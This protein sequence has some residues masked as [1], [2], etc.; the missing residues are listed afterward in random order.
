[1]N[2]FYF[3]PCCGLISVF[4]FLRGI[5][6]EWIGGV[7]VGTGSRFYLPKRNM[8]HHKQLV[9][10]F[11][12]E[13][14]I[15]LRGIWTNLRSISGTKSHGVFIFLRGIWTGILGQLIWTW[16]IVFIFLRGIWTSKDWRSGNRSHQVFIFLRGIWTSHTSFLIIDSFWFLSS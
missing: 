7:H 13:V 9:L 14:F 6:T 16:C 15:F 8:N 12:G 4:I 3:V 1:M 2:C 5:W 10:T 11:E